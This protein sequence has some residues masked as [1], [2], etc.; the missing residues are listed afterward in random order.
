MDKKVSRSEGELIKSFLSLFDA[1]K[2]KNNYVVFNHGVTN[3]R[4]V[5]RKY[6]FLST[7]KNTTQQ[8]SIYSE[9]RTFDSMEEACYY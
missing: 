2:I 8:I 4:V 5:C 3:R 7:L 1:N 6:P 9:V